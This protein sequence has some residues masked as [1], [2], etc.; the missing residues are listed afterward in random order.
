MNNLD[1]LE[2]LT[3]DELAAGLKMSTRTLAKWR[4]NGRGPLYVRLGH[5]VRYRKQDVADWLK[6]KISRNSTE[7]AE[8]R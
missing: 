1:N 8:R 4:C 2:L 6:A 5:G 3:P 7:A